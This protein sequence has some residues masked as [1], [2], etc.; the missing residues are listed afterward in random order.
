MRSR[1]SRHVAVGLVALVLGGSMLVTPSVRAQ[2][3]GQPK[4]DQIPARVMAALKAKFPKAEID[5]WTKESEGDIVLYDIEF[6]QAGRKFE[7]DIRDDGTIY[8]WERAIPASQ[9][10]AL[11]RRAVQSKYPGS[12][13]TEI[14]AVTAVRNGED[15]LEAYEIVLKT[16]GEK[17]EV[18]LT[19]APDGSILEVTP[20]A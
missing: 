16:A 8:N 14:M 17:E 18:E 10:P 15:V 1:G 20:R 11:V 2:E 19:V 13:L 4:A 9:L 7:A 6:R 3:K 5:K 12:T